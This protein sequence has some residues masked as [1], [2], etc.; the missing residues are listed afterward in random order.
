MYLCIRSSLLCVYTSIS[1]SGSLYKVQDVHVVLDMT[2]YNTYPAYMYEKPYT[3]VYTYV[4]V[5]INGIVC[6]RNAPL[7]VRTVS[8][9]TR[10]LLKCPEVSD[11]TSLSKFL[12]CSVE[13]R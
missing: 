12:P 9:E 1:I 10:S 8:S 6:I 2:S 5:Y 11:D 13:Q 7:S 3:H 4:N